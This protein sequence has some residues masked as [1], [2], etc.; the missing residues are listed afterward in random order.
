MQKPLAPLPS[1]APLEG[2]PELVLVLDKIRF[3]HLRD[4]YEYEE[5]LWFIREYPRV[6]RH[7]FDH[8]EYRLRSIRQAYE[9]RYAEAEA[10]LRREADPPERWISDPHVCRIYWNFESYL[11]AVSSS[12]DIAAR[13]V[14]TA[15]KGH[16]AANFNRFCKTSPES[17]LKDVFVRA[18]RRWVQRMK[19]YRDC[20]THFTPV[21]TLLSMGIRQYSD[22]WQLHAK[23]P[24]NP[25]AR[26]IMDFRYSR[27]AE[28]LAYATTV[29]N[30]L[31]A[32]D[33]AAARMLWR[34]YREGT[35]PQKVSGLFFLGRGRAPRQ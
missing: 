33:R 21:D 34:L 12:L 20:F 31:V 3:G 26:E 5:F 17:E 1:F 19:A 22:A 35:Y 32:F 11:Q 13:V 14:G 8:A 28:L 27:R 16:T 6:Y 4:D 2:S 18:Q 7:H 30:H 24:V 29:W 25:D 9:E 15:Y 23:I 10:V